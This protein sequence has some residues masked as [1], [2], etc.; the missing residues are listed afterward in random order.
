MFGNTQFV[1]RKGSNKRN[2]I[3]LIGRYADLM[4]FAALIISSIA[5]LTKQFSRR[6]AIMILAVFGVV[7]L[8]VL[9]D[10]VSE[11]RKSKQ[12]RQLIRNQILLEKL[13]LL[14]NEEIAKALGTERIKII[15]SEKP[16]K[17]ELLQAIAGQPEY[18]IC[19]KKDRRIMDSAARFAPQTK[20]VSQWELIEVMNIEC[21]EEEVSQRLS[22]DRKEKPKHDLKRWIQSVR[23]NRYLTLGIL[24]LVLSFV[25]KYKIYYRVLASVCMII[26]TIRGLFNHQKSMNNLRFFLDIIDR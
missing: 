25:T 1:K 5:V 21:L 9:L 6:R 7:L 24:L 12:K 18:L 26:S 22:D 15:R 8:I 4:L 17:W 16:G 13:Y 3:R 11:R 2:V 20:V 19:Q 23:W 10:R 14:K